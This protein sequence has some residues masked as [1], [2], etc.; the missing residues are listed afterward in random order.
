MLSSLYDKEHETLPSSHGR[1]GG[2][3]SSVAAPRQEKRS[4]G[5]LNWNLEV[6]KESEF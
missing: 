2:P 3:F 1:S 4:V 5:N 6:T